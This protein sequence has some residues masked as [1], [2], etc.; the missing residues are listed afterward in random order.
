[1]AKFSIVYKIISK[2]DQRNM[3]I[4]ALDKNDSVAKSKMKLSQLYGNDYKI[5]SSAKI[6]N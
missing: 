5:I 3:H 2:K 4:D 6:G 1:M